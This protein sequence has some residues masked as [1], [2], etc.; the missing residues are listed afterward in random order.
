MQE[1][2]PCFTFLVNPF[3]IDVINDGCLVR[4]PF[5]RDVFAAEMELTELQEDLALKNFDKCH[6]TVELWQQVTKRKYTEIKKASV[7]LPSVFSTTYCCESLFSVMKF[8][9]SKYRA[10]LTNEHLR[11]LIRTALT[12]YCPDFQKL[13][14]RMETH[15][16]SNA[17]K[18]LQKL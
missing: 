10:S 5:V 4:Q 18:N 11:E 1:L 2:K 8:V 7:R 17:G 3:D 13:A 6:S 14:N 9:K 16:S 12:S 15:T